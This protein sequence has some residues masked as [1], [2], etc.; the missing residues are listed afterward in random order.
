MGDRRKILVKLNKMKSK[1]YFK[2][3]MKQYEIFKHYE[4]LI[5]F[6]IDMKQ[7]KIFKHYEKL[8]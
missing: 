3:N 6:K 2:I 7:Y 1:F 8:T 4:K 5:Y